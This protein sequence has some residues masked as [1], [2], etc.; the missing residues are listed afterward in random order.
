MI[1]YK[2]SCAR[3]LFVGFRNFFYKIFLGSFENQH[4]RTFVLRSL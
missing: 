1:K 3:K 2:L 4:Y